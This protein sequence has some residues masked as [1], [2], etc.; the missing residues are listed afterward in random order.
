MCNFVRLFKRK[1][2]VKGIIKY[3]GKSKKEKRACI[4]LRGTKSA[5]QSEHLKSAIYS[6]DIQRLLRPNIRRLQP[7][8]C[9]RDEFKGEASVFLD[10]NENPY[11][12]PY[13]R[14]PVD[15]DGRIPAREVRRIVD[16][17][18][19]Y[20]G[21]DDGRAARRVYPS[22]PTPQMMDDYLARPNRSDIVGVDA[23][24]GTRPTVDART[25]KKPKAKASSGS[26]KAK[27]KIPAKSASKKTPAKRTPAKSTKAKTSGRR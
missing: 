1:V 12:A 2:K 11:N 16:G 26:C 21:V 13:N 8:A 6:M 14:Y 7:Y 19:G 23:P 20:S 22:R 3:K 10:A 18:V 17:R 25:Y 9:A 4:N 5:C 24:K 27:P 15:E